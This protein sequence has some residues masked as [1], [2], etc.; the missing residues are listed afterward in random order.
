LRITVND[1][2]V[3]S[4]NLSTEKFRKTIT[5]KGQKINCYFF[6]SQKVI[7]EEQ[8][9]IVYTVFGKRIKNE[10]VDFSYQIIKDMSKKVSCD[11]DVS[12]L[13]E[14]LVTHKE[15][16]QKNPQVNNVKIK[17]KKAFFE[18]LKE[19]DL[20]IKSINN[21]DDSNEIV[22]DLTK[23][24]D[25]ALQSNKE[26]NF[27]YPFSKSGVRSIL[28]PNKEGDIKITESGEIQKLN[29]I[30]YYS[31]SERDPTSSADQDELP[32]IVKDNKGD[33]IG[34]NK[35][36][37]SN[38]ISIIIKEFP[39]DPREGWI[40]FD[41]KAILFNSEHKFA[42]RFEN[43]KTLFDYNLTRVII[44]VLIKNKNDDEPMDALKTFEIF[45]KLL[46]EVWV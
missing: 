12:L 1:I 39:D 45:E 20:I 29:S 31:N 33:K 35:D 9:H 14:Y 13:A 11:A 46:H 4:N 30:N 25:T 26:L 27:L 23:R 18:F 19:Q 37:K 34:E 32:G 28:I 2:I 22:N 3:E 42:K 43:T 24:I 7:P 41:S 36:R 38:S 10:S 8:R 44:S 5:Y 40:D 6:T 17:I 16:F 15:D 21:I